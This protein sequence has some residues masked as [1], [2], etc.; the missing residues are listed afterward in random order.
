MKKFYNLAIFVVIAAVIIAWL[1]WFVMPDFIAGQVS[2]DNVNIDNFFYAHINSDS[3]FDN[4][5]KIVHA[6]RGWRAVREAWPA[7][8]PVL[9]FGCIVA[10]YLGRLFIDNEHKIK[11]DD[12]IKYNNEKIEAREKKVDRQ[13]SRAEKLKAEA[14]TSGQMAYQ[15]TEKA[16]QARRKAE[17]IEKAAVEQV[18]L[19]NTRT[20]EAE[21]KLSKEREDHKKTHAQLMRYKEKV[22]G[23]SDSP[24]N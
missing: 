20:E 2:N 17:A 6:A 14:E 24:P 4:V 1:H 18:N 3:K 21:R 11:A 19:A 9:F 8:I 10:W 15:Y 23:K 22:K 16:I 13:Y 12:E 5:T 7:I